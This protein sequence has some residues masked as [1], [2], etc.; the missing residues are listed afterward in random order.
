MII[1]KLA[2]ITCG[3]YLAIA[4]LLEGLLLGAARATGGVG[5]TRGAFFFLFAI[6]WLISFSL[7]WHFVSKNFPFKM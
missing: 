3:F 5:L 2:L 7:A 4:L 1:L 6:A